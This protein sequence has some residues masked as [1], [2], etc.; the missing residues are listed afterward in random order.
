MRLI[1]DTYTI[2]N[3]C[4]EPEDTLPSS[5]KQY[6][7]KLK[8]AFLNTFTGVISEVFIFLFKTNVV[9]KVVKTKM[10]ELIAIF[11]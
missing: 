8:Y 4:K 1:Q 10:S 9:M 2:N 7:F 5:W 6:H 11:C 3:T